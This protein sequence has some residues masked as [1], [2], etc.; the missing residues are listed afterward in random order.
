MTISSTVNFLMPLWNDAQY[1]ERIYEAAESWVSSVQNY[2]Q[3]LGK[4][5]SF[6]FVNYAAPFQNAMAG[7]GEENL[8]F[9][10]EVS[11][12]YDPDQVF[13]TAVPGGYKL[14]ETATKRP[15]D[16]PPYDFTPLDMGLVVLS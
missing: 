4:G 8:Q 3:S 11:R 2:T 12:K 9:L 7:Y 16:Y 10:R 5:H 14:S 15:R 1:D 6:E 13:Q